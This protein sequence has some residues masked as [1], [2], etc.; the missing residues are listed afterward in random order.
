MI[1]SKKLFGVRVDILSGDIENEL[2]SALGVKGNVIVPLT[3]KKLLMLRRN[4][5]LR[6]TVNNAFLVLPADRFVQW[7]VRF[8]YKI[9]VPLVTESVLLNKIFALGNAKRLSYF[10]YGSTDE[11]LFVLQQKLKRLYPG[12]TIV[13]AYREKIPDGWEEKVIEGIRKTDATFLLLMMRFPRDMSFI[14]E[15]KDKLHLTFYLGSD[16]LNYFSGRKKPPPP[17]AIDRGLEWLSSALARPWRIHAVFRYL[18]FLILVLFE[19]F[20]RKDLR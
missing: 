1:E 12:L 14:A 2:A 11:H 10:F 8:L 3:M 6:E 15:H 18:R 7:A 16:A 5:K 13:G 4:A 9:Y 17:W 20:T 19:K